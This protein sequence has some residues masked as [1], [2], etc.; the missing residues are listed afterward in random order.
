MVKILGIFSFTNKGNIYYFYFIILDDLIII[1][2]FIDL[3]F[4]INLKIFINNKLY[5]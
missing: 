5:I 1:K 3:F 2:K 4:I